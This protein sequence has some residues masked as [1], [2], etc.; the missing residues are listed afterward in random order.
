MN[1]KDAIKKIAEDPNTLDSLNPREFEEV[2]AE[3]FASAGYSVQLTPAT[4][5]GGYDLMVIHRDPLGIER[6]SI[7][8][9]KKYNIEN[10]VG[11]NLIRALY[12]VKTFLGVSD[13]ILL[14]TSK[15]TQ[16]SKRFVESKHDIKLIDRTELLL[17]C[18]AYK[19]PEYG[20]FHLSQRRFYSCFIS[21]SSK[22]KA[23]VEKLNE[24]LRL[25]GVHVWYAPEDLL[26]GDK[27]YEQIKRAI[28]SFDKLL[29]VLS[30]ESIKSNW[31]ITEIL[32]ARQKEDKEGNQVLFPMAI[33]SMDKIKT[34]QCFDSDSGKDVA[35][36]VREYF[37]PD[38]SNWQDDE[39]FRVNAAK[40][41][42]GLQQGN[43]SHNDDIKGYSERI[44]KLRG[45][46]YGEC[47]FDD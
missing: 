21:H 44:S 11:V 41:L 45:R 46:M 32:N 26:P 5:D 2:A 6:T 33:T 35:K 34:W 29:L 12:G 42:K 38:L 8:E 9:C 30:E 18:G 40:L 37:I 3:I 16:D 23:F 13:G 4:R 43:P 14:T 1:A 24:Y 22:D 27:I 15:F 25:N 47:T 31:V 10:K 19:E 17:W 39:S 36:E 28:E 7:V 20:D